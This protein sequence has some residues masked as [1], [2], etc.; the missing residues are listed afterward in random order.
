MKQ[1]IIGR[2]FNKISNV[3]WKLNQLDQ[4]IALVLKIKCKYFLQKHQISIEPES[5]N[6]D[7]W[8]IQGFQHQCQ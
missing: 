6:G 3:F 5:L 1:K 8:Y 2:K 4:D 7:A